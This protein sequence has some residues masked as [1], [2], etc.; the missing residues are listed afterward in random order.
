[1][2]NAAATVKAGLEG[3]KSAAVNARSNFTKG[4]ANALYIT[5]AA[6]GCKRKTSG[7]AGPP[8]FAKEGK[9]NRA[10]PPPSFAKRGCRP[11]AQCH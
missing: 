4:A 10:K 7:P 9:E 2:A 6:Q 3:G 1:M 8:S 5:C 11:Q